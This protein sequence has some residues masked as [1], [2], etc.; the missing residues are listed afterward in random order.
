[1]ESGGRDN[2]FGDEWRGVRADGR[3]IQRSRNCERGR[4]PVSGEYLDNGN[5]NAG[6]Q[7]GRRWRRGESADGDGHAAANGCRNEC[8]EKLEVLAGNARWG[9]GGWRRGRERG[10][11]SVQSRGGGDRKRH[12]NAAAGFGTVERRFSSGAG[13]FGDLC[14]ISAKHGDVWDGGGDPNGGDGW[15]IGE[16]AS[17]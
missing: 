11:Q 10:V 14:G 1:M 3:E 13:E 12:G 4:Y 6:S 9:A 15:K 17:V 16:R 2:D 8:G 5:G 7:R